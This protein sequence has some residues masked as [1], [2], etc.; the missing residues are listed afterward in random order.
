[1]IPGHLRGSLAFAV[2]SAGQDAGP[3]GARSWR[4]TGTA[5]PFGIKMT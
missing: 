5:H 3:P 1:V 2:L 4:R